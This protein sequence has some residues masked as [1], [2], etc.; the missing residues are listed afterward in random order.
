[1][2]ITLTLSEEWPQ[3]MTSPIIFSGSSSSGFKFSDRKKSL[4]EFRNL[5]KDAH[6]N[7][8]RSDKTCS[9]VVTLL[10][11]GYGT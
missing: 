1:M 6:N 2:P 9:L 3:K 5:D 7:N 10:G 4:H 11:I 8:N